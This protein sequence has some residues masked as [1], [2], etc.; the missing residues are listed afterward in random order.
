MYYSSHKL[1]DTL[2]L[3]EGFHHDLKEK[4]RDELSGPTFPWKRREKTLKS[5]RNP[6]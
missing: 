2:K 5:W 6:H 4:D 1:P 3:K